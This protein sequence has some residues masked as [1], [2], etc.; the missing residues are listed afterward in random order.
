[1]LLLLIFIIP[2]L[3]LYLFFLGIL[4]VIPGSNRFLGEAK[5]HNKVKYIFTHVLL[6]LVCIGIVIG[7]AVLWEDLG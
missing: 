3:L 6:L 1:M 2:V 4:H 7:V 5:Q